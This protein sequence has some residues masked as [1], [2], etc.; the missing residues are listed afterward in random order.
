[1][2]S[3][4]FIILIALLSLGFHSLGQGDLLIAPTRV[5]F[6][7]NKQKEGL[8]L[9]NIGKDTAIY[10]I[11]FVQ[12]NQTEAGGYQI[13]TKPD[14]GQMFADPYLRIFPRTVT[15]APGEPQVVMIQYRRKTDMLA[16]EYRS[17]LYFRS[18]KNYKPL[19]SKNTDTITTISV[20]LTPIYGIT[21]PIIIHSG[22]V[23]VSSTLSDLKLE[24]VQDSITNINLNINRAGNI[25]IYGELSVE[26][27]PEQGKPIQ[28]GLV[29]GVGVYTNI[30]KRNI[31][32]K[33]N[34]EPGVNLTSGKLKVQYIGNED[35]KRLVY[36]ESEIE[37]KPSHIIVDYSN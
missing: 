34:K 23:N 4:L 37:L 32:I 36:A 7:G 22:A 33:L 16:G 14:A 27:I 25:S 28:I 18:E 19:G 26:Y 12:Y 17:H 1:M 3:K 15:L 21:I 29:K 35:N 5:V 8:N 2:K 11:S 31:S 30:N 20:K 10:S 6:E 24:I 9:V 13:I